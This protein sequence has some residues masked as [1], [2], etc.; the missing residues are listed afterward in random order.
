MSK[1]IIEIKGLWFSYDKDKQEKEEKYWNWVLKDINLDIYPGEFVAIIGQ[2]GAGKTTLMKQINGLNLPDKGN[3]MI[4][5]QNLKDIKFN[6]KASR[7]G[8]VYQNPDHQ[9]FNLTVDSEISFG[10][11]HLGVPEEEINKGIE[12][13]KAAVGLTDMGAEY[14]FALGRGQRQKLAVASVLVM[15]PPILIIDEP[16]TG[17]DWVGGVAMMDLIQSLHKQGHTIIMITHDMRIV[18]MYA[19]RVVVMAQGKILLDNSPK[20]V[21]KQRDIL[22]QAFLQPSQINR[23]YSKLSE[24]FDIPKDILSVDEAFEHISNLIMKGKEYGT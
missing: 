5:Q 22:S 21:F 16:T 1:P 6:E 8:Y 18:S 20:E 23:I 17:L 4:N 9:I 24:S 11:R 19:H 10:P 14:P 3:V 15:N 7:I 12:T 2:N 13:V